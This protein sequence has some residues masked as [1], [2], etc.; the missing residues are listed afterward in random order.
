MTLSR[1]LCLRAAA[2]TAVLSVAVLAQ[3]PF[4]NHPV[5]VSLG[6][7]GLVGRADFDGDGDVD[8]LQLLSASPG[9]PVIALRVL[10]NDGAANF[11]PGAT[12]ALPAGFGSWARVAPV[13]ADLDGDGA[14]DVGVDYYDASVSPAIGGVALVRGD[15][16][17][18][19]VDVTALGLGIEV[20]RLLP[21]QT[22]GDPQRELILHGGASGTVGATRIQSVGWSAAGAVAAPPTIVPPFTVLGTGVSEL[23]VGDFTGNGWT[24]VASV[25]RSGGIVTVYRSIGDGEFLTAQQFGLPLGGSLTLGAGDLDG[26]DDDDLIAY[27]KQG[28]ATTYEL[29]VCLAVDG[30]LVPQPVQVG[31]AIVAATARLSVADWD[32]DGLPDLLLHR[33]NLG[34]LRGTA[35]GR[36]E[37]AGVVASNGQLGAGHAD[38]NGDGSLDFAGASELALGTGQFPSGIAAGFSAF[39]NDMVYADW[40]DDGDVD[41]LGRGNAVLVNDGRGRF[42]PRFN[43][44]PGLPAGLYYDAPT[45]FADLDR[46]GRRDYLVARRF[47][48]GG[49]LESMVAL[50]DDGRGRYATVGPVT[51]GADIPPDA[52]FERYGASDV[53]GDGDVDVLHENGFYPANGALS[54][55]GFVAAWRGGGLLTCD[56]DAD[57]DRDVVAA[58]ATPSGWQVLFHEAVG[59][60]YVERLL[61]VADERVRPALRD[62]DDDGDLDLVAAYPGDTSVYLVE[63]VAGVLSAVTVLDGSMPAGA[64]VGVIDWDGDGA[65]DLLVGRGDAV[66]VYRRVGP[67]LVYE[68]VADRG[69]RATPVAFVD[70]DGDGDLDLV[71]PTIVDNERFPRSLTGG[72]RQYGEGTNGTG[73]VAPLLGVAGSMWSGG[74]AP[75]TLRLRR[76]VGGGVAVV[77]V[78][79]EAAEVAGAPLPG[80]TLW[81]GP[82][83]T[84][85]LLPVGG[86]SGA[87]GA[88]D[89]DLPLPISPNL[90]QLTLYLQAFASDAQGPAGWSSSNGIELTFGR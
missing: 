55:G 48:V 74:R 78:S 13:V 31:P 65:S 85:L 68:L 36:F 63:N 27:S 81:I 18:G 58:D 62:L 49:A 15:G 44:W 29:F 57:G 88:G 64:S 67:G 59:G 43:L 7:S 39:P 77:G 61:F 84:F 12:L 37:I 71:G 42:S 22:D 25:S 10:R 4:D 8:L 16:A 11:S 73:G 40:D 82:L 83:L 34:L 60:A 72:N 90:H 41:V 6:E 33:W 89:F 52:S 45:V 32:A 51:A 5:K 56:L 21:G 30:A 23:A 20:F 19:F 3:S 17:G 14:V 86:A 35:L 80:H 50:I 87:A 47:V 54:F 38:F 46:D 69:V 53:D 70:H 1:C 26:D 9:G 76:A 75:A 66:G 24:D 2:C 28:A 79:I